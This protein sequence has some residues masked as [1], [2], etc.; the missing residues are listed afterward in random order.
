MGAWGRSTLNFFLIFYVIISRGEDEAAFLNWLRT[1][2]RTEEDL[3]AMEP[4]SVN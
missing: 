2:R 1:K 4:D 3:N